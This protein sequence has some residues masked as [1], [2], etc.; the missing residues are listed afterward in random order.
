MI[1]FNSTYVYNWHAYATATKEQYKAYII[2]LKNRLAK[3]AEEKFY[4]GAKLI[5]FYNSKD[6]SCRCEEAGKYIGKYLIDRNSVSAVFFAVCEMELGLERTQVSRLMNVVSEF[7]DKL[8]GFAEKWKAYNYSQLSEMLSLTS[9]QRKKVKPD[10]TIK[11]IREYKKSLVATS[12]QPENEAE[13][14]AK[15]KDPK[16]ERFAKYSKNDCIDR[17]LDLEDENGKL[18]AQLLLYSDQ[19]NRV[20]ELEAQLATA[21]FKIVKKLAVCH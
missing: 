3:T 17:I 21:D 11:Q 6:Y 13:Q 5:D 7:G 18:R 4:L 1:D 20:S 19:A 16:Y 12:Q 9:E 10:W 2:D 14:E 8:I 15:P